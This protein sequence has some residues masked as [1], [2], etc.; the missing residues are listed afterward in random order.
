MYRRSEFDCGRFGDP[1]RGDRRVPRRGEWREDMGAESSYR[2]PNHMDPSFQHRGPP[3][4]HGPEF[5]GHQG[6]G[7]QSRNS[8]DMDEVYRPSPARRIHVLKYVCIVV[9]CHRELR[10]LR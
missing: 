7:Y 8:S 2:P 10:G 4:R 6:T 1:I 3:E 9:G 5:Y